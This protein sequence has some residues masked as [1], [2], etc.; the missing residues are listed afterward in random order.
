MDSLKAT[1]G[2]AAG[3]S[4]KGFLQKMKKV[5]AVITTNKE[6]KSSKQFKN[7]GRKPDKCYNCGEKGHS[8]RECKAE[9]TCFYCKKKEHTRF[10]CSALKRK[11]AKGQGH[12]KM[13]T[14]RTAVNEDTATGETVAAVE[15]Q[16][17]ELV[18]SALFVQVI[19]VDGKKC[20]LLM[21]VDTNSLVSF[22]KYKA[23]EQ[24]VKPLGNCANG[25]IV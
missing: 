18:V 16:E 22:I 1:A 20:D 13:S 9:K 2:L 11:D 7:N 24:K 17:R 19:D 4:F 5:A 8:T 6:R 14:A 23:F 15:R 3:N 21:L 12:N 25:E 10:D